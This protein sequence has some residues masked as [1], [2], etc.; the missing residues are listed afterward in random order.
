MAEQFFPTVKTAKFLACVKNSTFPCNYSKS[1]TANWWCFK[2]PR[3]RD[4]NSSKFLNHV[5]IIV[6]CRNWNKTFLYTFYKHDSI[7]HQHNSMHYPD[8]LP[9]AFQSYTKTQMLFWIFYLTS[10][11]T[12]SM[13]SLPVFW[14]HYLTLISCWSSFSCNL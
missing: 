11:V 9:S 6:L 10:K 7:Y 8:E 2:I 4:N 12:F 13:F 5:N 14:S 1:N 3:Y